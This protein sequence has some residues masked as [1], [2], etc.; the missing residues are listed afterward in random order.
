MLYDL[1]DFCF[2]GGSLKY[3]SVNRFGKK[4]ISKPGNCSAVFDKCSFKK[5]VWYILDQY[6]LKFGSKVFLLVKVKQMGS[7]PVLV[8][9]NLF[10]FTMRAK[11]YKRPSR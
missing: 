5:A 3:I 2:Y 9:A 11:G 8:M 6:F 4:W 7:N 1:T 10:V